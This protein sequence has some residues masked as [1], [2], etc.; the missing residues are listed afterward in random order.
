MHKNYLVSQPFVLT[1]DHTRTSGYIQGEF[2]GPLSKLHSDCSFLLAKEILRAK[3]KQDWVLIVFRMKDYIACLV[4]ILEKKHTPFITSTAT[5]NPSPQFDVRIM[6]R[7]RMPYFMLI[8]C[9]CSRIVMYSE[10]LM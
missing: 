4:D 6:S 3:R 7:Y 2:V 10:K 8:Y 9:D 1:N 5:R